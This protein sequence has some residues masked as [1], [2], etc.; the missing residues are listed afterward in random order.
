MTGDLGRVQGASTALAPRARPASTR[1]SDPHNH[2]ND[3][4]GEAPSGFLV[5]AAPRLG[6]ESLDRYPEP[7]GDAQ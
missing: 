5:I 1:W 2:R 4:N 6:D 7:G 3:T